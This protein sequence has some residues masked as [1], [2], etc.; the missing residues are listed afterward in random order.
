MVATVSEFK[1][2]NSNVETD[3][4]LKSQSVHQVGYMMYA[5]E[6]DHKQ[7]LF[8]TFLYLYVWLYI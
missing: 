7:C 5:I 2:H 1:G 4:Y 6:S 8:F 3:K